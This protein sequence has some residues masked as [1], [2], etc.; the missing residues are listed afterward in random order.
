EGE[1]KKPLSMQWRAVWGEVVSFT[2]G[3]VLVIGGGVLALQA[4]G[5]WEALVESAAVTSQYTALTF[6]GDDFRALM[7][8]ALGF[9]WQ[10]WGALLVLAATWFVL[11]RAGEPRDQTWWVVVM[12]LLAGL[13]IMLVQAKGYDYHW[14]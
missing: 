3:L 2:L 9:R 14:L 12:W 6:N 4:M 10:Q 7:G 13:A 8:T 11:R 1:G 5:A